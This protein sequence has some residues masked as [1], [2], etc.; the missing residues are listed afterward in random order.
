MKLKQKIR[1][2][3]KQR[4]YTMIEMMVGIAVFGVITGIC[5]LAL[6]QIVTIPEK[7]DSQ[8]DA[9]HELQNVIHWVS[10]DA[11]SAVSAIGGGNVTL[12]MP[13]ESVIVYRRS[14]TTLYR[15]YADDAQ[16]VARNIT[17]LN[18]T[19][20]GRIITMDITSAPGSRWNISEHRTYQIAMRSSGS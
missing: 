17:S 12:A 7:G 1:Q 15:Y 19:V 4:G 20:D 18:F 11:G 13:D 3:K 8:V 2:F 5:G 10:L 6:Q 14:G 16:T 9:L